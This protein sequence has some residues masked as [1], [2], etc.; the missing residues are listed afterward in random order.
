MLIKRVGNIAAVTVIA[1]SILGSTPNIG[2]AYAAPAIS[3]Q[4][5]DVPLIFDAAPRID[6]GVTYVPFRTV[7]EALGID[8]T[9]NSKSQTVKATNTVKGQ[10]TEVLLQVGSTTATV[11]GKKLHLLQHPFSGRAAY[12]FH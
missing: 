8:I 12:L 10:T 1:L 3:V 4:L 5:D 2:G 9:W 6:R 11:N 7:G